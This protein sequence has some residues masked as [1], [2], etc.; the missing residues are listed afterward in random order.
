VSRRHR[1]AAHLLYPLVFQPVF[2]VEFMSAMALA[3]TTE[4]MR[5]LVEPPPFSLIESQGL[6]A[7]LA[8][9]LR[10]AG[11][12]L[13]HN[14]RAFVRGLFAA[15]QRDSKRRRLIQWGLLTAILV[16]SAFLVIIVVAGWHRFMAPVAENRSGVTWLP[17]RIA[18]TPSITE[19]PK[20][21]KGSEDGGGGGGGQSNPLPAPKGVLPQFV[22][23][24]PIV[25]PTSPQVEAPS[26]PMPDNLQ[27]SLTDPPPPAAHGDPS[28]KGTNPSGGTG[29]GGGLGNG[30][31]PGVGPG[32]G[33]GSGRGSGG[34]Q[35]YGI[36]SGTSDGSAIT[37]ID[38]RKV[39]KPQGFVPFKWLY[40]PTPVTTAEAQENKVIGFVV[41]RA[42]F[43]AD[44]TVSD[45]EVVQ[46]VEFMTDS[47]IDSLR[48]SKFKPATINGKPVTL[49]NVPIRVSVHY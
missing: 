44:G 15:D 25:S 4:T 37:D 19:S 1:A 20:P 46:P 40:R 31:G 35:G 43:N 6:L 48:R 11:G 3:G 12:E 34:D 29:N 7:R 10:R 16:H 13:V 5:R 32:T 21:P 28:G 38:F 14:P 23:H 17:P 30:S 22:P 9:E 45:I 42:S 41:L 18:E 8:E 39:E 26:M 49:R 33:P 2:P 27:G 24:P 47:A 36:K